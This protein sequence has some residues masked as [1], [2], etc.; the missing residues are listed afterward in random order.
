[1]VVQKGSPDMEQIRQGQ[2]K[3]VLTD[4]G[5]LPGPVADA[6]AIEAEP[7]FAPF[8]NFLYEMAANQSVRYGDT[9]ALTD[10][11]LH[12]IDQV[13]IAAVPGE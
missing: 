10:R 7:T 11:Y 12:L 1:M 3:S 5:I 13:E 8:L 9:M 2:L 4:Q 6:S